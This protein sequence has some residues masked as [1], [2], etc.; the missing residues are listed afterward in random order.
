MPPTRFAA[1][2][3][4]GLAAGSP[5]RFSRCVPGYAALPITRIIAPLFSLAQFARCGASELGRKV[6]I[7]L[8][9]GI[10]KDESRTGMLQQPADEVPPRVREQG[11]GIARNKRVLS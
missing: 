10:A 11:R 5:I 3:K 4:Y 1:R 6:F 8:K 9:G 2:Y 7:S